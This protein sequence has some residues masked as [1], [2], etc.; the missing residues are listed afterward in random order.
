MKNENYIFIKIMNAE[1]QNYYSKK[2]QL[3]ENIKLTKTFKSDKA[4]RIYNTCV[5]HDS[6][7]ETYF[8]DDWIAKLNY[9]E[10]TLIRTDFKDDFEANVVNTA[11]M[12][13]YFHPPEWV[14]DE[15]DKH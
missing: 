3:I 10:R 6:K 1:V 4:E 8:F 15:N 11:W 13:F 14:K 9:D 12:Q 5:K 7:F 2:Q